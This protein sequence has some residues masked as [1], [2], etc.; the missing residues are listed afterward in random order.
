MMKHNENLKVVAEEHEQLKIAFAEQSQRS[1]LFN[2][3]YEQ[4]IRFTLVPSLLTWLS[5]VVVILCIIAFTDL[6]QASVVLWRLKTNI[7]RFQTWTRCYGDTTITLRVSTTGKCINQ[8]TKW[9][10]S[11]CML[12]ALSFFLSTTKQLQELEKE[13]KKIVQQLKEKDAKCQG[14]TV[15]GLDIVI[16]SFYWFSVA[17]V[18]R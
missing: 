7:K 3:V 12:T 5:A 15:S 17:Y 14:I 9:C 2:Y 6:K 10:H 13:R 16:S 8:A 4:E 1:V 11:L 18:E